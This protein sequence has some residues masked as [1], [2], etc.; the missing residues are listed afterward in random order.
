MALV[1]QEHKEFDEYL[2]RLTELAPGTPQVMLLQAAAAHREGD[3][4]KAIEL[5]SR[6]YE[7]APGTKTMLELVG[8]QN[9]GGNR[10]EAT[11]L[12]QQ[13]VKDH[14]QDVPARLA[15]A[16]SLENNQQAEEAAAHYATVL[17][18]APDNVAALNNLAWHL[19]SK[20]RSRAES[21]AQKANSLA[22]DQP[23]ILDTLAVIEFLGGDYR[24]AHRSIERALA[25]APDSPS[26]LYHRAMIIAEMGEQTRA[27]S[28]LQSLLAE[29]A[30]DFPE[31]ADAAALLAK[32][33]AN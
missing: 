21:Y 12:L 32:L 6:T 24:R 26:L 7:A 18:H 5:A 2:A 22:P 13:W 1:E 10:A 9:A 30:T 15:L 17:E 19:R 20:D 23:Q 33:K 31:R 3:T 25:A 14:P 4:D 27:I 16:G 8:Y 29:G 28:Q 11:Q